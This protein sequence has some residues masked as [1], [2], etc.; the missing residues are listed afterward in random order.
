M[1]EREAAVEFLLREC[2]DHTGR[3]GDPDD[4]PVVV[5]WSARGSPGSDLLAHL[6]QIEHWSGP[7]A[8]LDSARLPDS[9]RPH[10]VANRL[11]LQL[12]WRVKGFGRA[13]FPRFLLGMWAARNPLDPDATAGARAARRELI[14][15]LIGNRTELRAWVRDMARVLAEAGGLPGPASEAFGLAVDG[16][17]GLVHTRL[18]LRRAGM[19]WYRTG[20]NL[21]MIQDAADGLVE[22][23]VREFQGNHGWVDEVLCRAFVADLRAAYWAKRWIN[24]CPVGAVVLLDNVSIGPAHEFLSTLAAQPGGSGPLLVVAASHRRYPPDA[25]KRPLVWQPDPLRDASMV[26]WLAG[27][28]GRGGSRFYPVWVD[29]V[30]DVAPISDPA[31]PEV[32]ATT[33]RLVAHRS[34]AYSPELRASV[35]FAYRLTSAHQAGL[36]MVLDALLRGGPEDDPRRVLGRSSGDGA[37]PLDEQVMELVLGP[38]DDHLRQGLVLMAMVV[39]LSDTSI[40]PI[41]D[42]LTPHKIRMIMEF[43]AGDLWVTYPVEDGRLRA[44]RL[45]PFARRAIAHRLAGPGGL[46][47][48]GLTWEDVHELLR[49]DARDKR[50][51][52]VA[53]YHSLALGR[54]QQVATALTGEFRPG[55]QER[56]YRQLTRVTA[57]PLA[58]P[59]QGADA[60]ALF[61]RLCADPAPEPRVSRRLVAALQLHSDPL[62]D[63]RH[64]MCVIVADELLEL[65]RHAGAGARF[66]YEQHLRF[67][68]CS[69]RWHSIGG[70]R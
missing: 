59:G 53:L 4:R 57:A 44:P 34:L 19:R 22:L 68:E 26:R 62:G 40:A 39:D 45:H 20:L 61:G 56:F 38:R 3:H 9:H 17:S 30:D 65:S 8:Y 24:A 10:E 11:A 29:P 2:A 21:A 52:G 6:R 51:E 32:E 5:L 13:G 12:G 15:K 41:L 25:A 23:S 35:A 50:R 7:R 48:L 60:N 58:V 66:L 46:P 67:A 43:R 36:G 42:L 14:R 37:P 27:R 49:A 64:D 18:L 63:P 31:Q 54:V 69:R 33:E 28:D 16:L 47:D 70:S 1:G 55:N